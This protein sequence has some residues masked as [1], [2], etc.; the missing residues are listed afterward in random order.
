MG[1]A[2]ALLVDTT[3]QG[4]PLNYILDGQPW[5]REAAG[6]GETKKYVDLACPAENNTVINITSVS[7]KILPII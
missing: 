2:K 6:C 7:E 3:F 1:L 4:C 5:Y